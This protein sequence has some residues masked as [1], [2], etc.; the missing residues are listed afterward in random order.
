M[1]RPVKP[2]LRQYMTRMSAPALA[3]FALVLA[4]C[5]ASDPV[6]STQ[7][8]SPPATTV[9]QDYVDVLPSIENTL[10]FI[11]EA[12]AMVGPISTRLMGSALIS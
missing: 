5:G 3:A 4:S 8:E 7:P 1:D 6:S 2:V 12:G 11:R 9:I 10:G